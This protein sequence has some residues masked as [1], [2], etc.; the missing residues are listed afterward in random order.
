MKQAVLPQP[1]S[2][3]RTRGFTLVEVLIVLAVI[4]II[5]AIA[6]PRMLS[7]RIAANEASAV[8][9]LRAIFSAQ[10]GFKQ[11]LAVD[12]DPTPDSDAEYGYLAELAGSVPLRG[13]AVVLNP[14]AASTKMGLVQM[15]VVTAGGY[16][17]AVYL[18]GPGGIGVAE[19]ANGGKAVA[20]SIDP[21][22]AERYWACYAWP[23]QRNVSGN[24]AYV[25]TQ[26][27][28]ILRSDNRAPT[29]QY[30]GIATMPAFDAAYSVAGD[31]RRKPI[32]DAIGVDGGRWNV[33]R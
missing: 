22:L 31:M 30:S 16:H 29:Q 23:V 28:D 21:D 2:P 9:T 18:P 12:N 14:P 6:L 7:S 25:V 4:A 8:S 10:A 17:F 15:S 24:R 11:R 19:D 20:A 13:S 33:V 26:E 32:V 1:K 27:G 3:R 5:A